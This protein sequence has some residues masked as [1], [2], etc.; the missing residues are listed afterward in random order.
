MIGGSTFRFGFRIVTAVFPYRL[1]C[2]SDS[3]I[4]PACHGDNFHRALEFFVRWER[5]LGGLLW[6]LP[7]FRIYV[8]QCRPSI[9]HLIFLCL[10]LSFLY[11]QRTIEIPARFV[12]GPFL[13]FLP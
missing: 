4:H 11:G 8:L 5:I 2:M 1:R 9:Y 6:L 10:C 3:A 13:R 12:L 7:W